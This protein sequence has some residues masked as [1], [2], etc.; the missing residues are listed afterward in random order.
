VVEFEEL[1]WAVKVSQHRSL[2]QAA[3]SLNVR[4]ST[5]SRRLRNLESQLGTT[6]FER[7][8]GGTHATPAG[9]EFLQSAERILADTD[10]AVRRAR[11]HCQGNA[12]RLGIGIYASFSTGYMQATLAD[13]R[14]RFPEVDLHTLDGTRGRLISALERGTIDVAIMTNVSAGW[15][16]R[17][18]SLWTERVIVPLPQQHPLL[19]VDCLGWRHLAGLMNPLI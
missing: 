6:L 14:A 3:Q 15:D 18:L 2:R 10:A 11:Q 7:T 8:H 13:Y 1:M 19:N 12:G 4:Q 16:D 9:L 5:L 17:T